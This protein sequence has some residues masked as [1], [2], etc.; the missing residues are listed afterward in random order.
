MARPEAG[1]PGD[2]NMLGGR[3]TVSLQAENP[4][5]GGSSGGTPVLESPVSGFFSL[6][7]LTG[8]ASLPEVWVKIVD[9]RG[10]DGRFWFFYAGLTNLA[11]TLT[12]HD[13]VTGDSRSYSGSGGSGSE[14]GGFDTSWPGDAP[15]ESG[16]P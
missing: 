14:C 7:E 13:D 6:P 5:T 16:R 11:Y 2:L 10:L 4:R 3:F 12:V 9:A 1:S 15:P 8:S